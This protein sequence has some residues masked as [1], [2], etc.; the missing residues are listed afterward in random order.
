MPAKEQRYRDSNEEP[1]KVF[2][3][4]NTMKIKSTIIPKQNL[5]QTEKGTHWSQ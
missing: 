1:W 3:Q 2:K 4:S 5:G